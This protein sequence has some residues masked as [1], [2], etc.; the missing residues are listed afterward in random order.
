MGCLYGQPIFVI[1]NNILYIFMT[2][3]EIF[4][5]IIEHNK[6][7]GGTLA[8][9]TGFKK[10]FPD[11]YEEFSKTVFPP[12][13]QDFK[14]IQKL[15]HFL[16]DDYTIPLCK[17]GNPLK[18]RAFWY[19]YNT[20]CR[21]NCPAMIENQVKCVKEKNELRSE[22]D[23]KKISD[24]ITQVFLDKYGVVRYS[25]TKDWRKKTIE[26]NN[27]KFG[28]DWYSQTDQ[29]RQ[30]YEKSCKEKY[31]DDITNSFQD[32]NVKNKIKEKFYKN[33]LKNHPNVIE[34][35]KDTL[36]CR[37][38]DPTCNL[39]KEK[40]YEIKKYTFSDRNCHNLDTCTNRSPY[41]STDSAP[42]KEVC[43]YIQS[44][45]SGK[46]IKNDRS[47]ID[48]K[49]LDIFLPELNLAFEF[50]GVY[51]HSE[52]NKPINYHQKKSLDCARQNIQLI[53]IWE[54]DWNNKKDII[55]D[56][57]KT[58]MHLNDI[59][60]GARKCEIHKISNT[61][62]YDFLNKYHIQGG[63]KNGKSIG[64]FYQGELV[65]VMVFGQLR[66]NM[67]G[68]PMDGYYEIYRFCSKADYDIQGG[69][70]KLLTFF[71]KEY[72]PIQVI[73]YANF[74]YTYGNVYFKCGFNQALISKPV[75]TWVVNGVRRYR[76]NFMKSKLEECIKNP[77][78]TENEVMHNRGCWKCWD[79]GKIKFT[80]NYR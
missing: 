71:E 63:V 73:T 79:A 26:K 76:S 13:F 22:E 28:A 64:L 52:F 39:C 55:K 33:F 46:I 62:S 19:G 9:K 10:W 35:K 5:F 45:Y 23:K 2:K 59:K 51:W 48:G 18:F 56:I 49:E 40:K 68:K 44:I 78:L 36:I 30:Q 31:G 66:K 50:N 69:I 24:K 1:F 72:H 12:E 8:T 67:G 37:C 53:H 58:K 77:N 11:M 57:I 6:E 15:W 3:S 14:F 16:K 32:E 65:E 42:E 75:Y 80:K 60:I 43:E 25:Q 74:D 29:Y 54:D 27:E 38:S 21:A 34:I 41:G 4:D 61:E 47:V 20:F 70:S 7:H 17:C